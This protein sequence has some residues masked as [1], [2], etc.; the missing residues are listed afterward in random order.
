M[1]YDVFLS[2]SHVD[3]DWTRQLHDRLAAT[4]APGGLQSGPADAIELIF[5]RTGLYLTKGTLC[6]ASLYQKPALET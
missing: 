6:I 4:V 1:S 3:K 2:H 5:G